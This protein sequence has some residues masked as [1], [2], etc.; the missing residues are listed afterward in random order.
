[1]AGTGEPV[2]AHTAVIL[3]LISGLSARGQT[4]NHISRTDIGIVND[5][6]T[7]HAA[8]YRRVYDNGAYQ[9]ADVG[10]LTAGSIYAHTHFAEFGKQFVRSVDDGGN[11]FP[12]NKQL[13]ASDST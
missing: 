10:S 12:R 11:H 9:I 4:Y 2:A 5:I 1:M 13:I 3:F 8:S 7:F 6:R